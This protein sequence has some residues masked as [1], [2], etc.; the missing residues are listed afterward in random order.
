[1]DRRVCRPE[2]FRGKGPMPKPW[3]RYLSPGNE[4]QRGLCVRCGRRLCSR[5][6]GAVCDETEDLDETFGPAEESA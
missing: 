6:K 4:A 1:M 2:G 3:F 5:A